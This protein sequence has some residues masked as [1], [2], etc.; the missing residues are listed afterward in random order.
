[1]TCIVG[2]KTSDGITIGGDSALSA[3][4][5][6][7]QIS[8]PKVFRRG[9]FVIGCC[10]SLRVLQLVHF[11]LSIPPLKGKELYKYMVVDFVDAMRKCFKL[12]GAARKDN[13]EEEVSG[14]FVVGIMDR[15]FIINDD[16]AVEECTDGFAVVGSGDE[17]SMGSLYSTVSEPN[18]ET[19]VILAL[20]AASYF[21]KSV[22]PPYTILKVETKDVKKKRTKGEDGTSGVKV[23]EG[24]SRKKSAVAEKPPE[25]H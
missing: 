16:Y 5:T 8:G 21:C 17:Y 20:E 24:K 18:N 3:G 1:M 4:D 7:R 22:A 2:L 10:D 25:R 6:V 9:Q 11:K 13:E 19:R 12:S 14:T 23:E 15:L